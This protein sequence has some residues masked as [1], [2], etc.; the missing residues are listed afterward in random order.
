M[1]AG[2]YAP[3]GEGVCVSW[4][5]NDQSH[6]TRGYSVRTGALALDARRNLHQYRVLGSGIC[7]IHVM[8]TAS[9][10]QACYDWWHDKP[11]F[12][13]PTIILQY[14]WIQPLLLLDLDLIVTCIMYSSVWGQIRVLQV[15]F[16]FLEDGCSTRWSCNL[17]V[18]VKASWPVDQGNGTG[19]QWSVGHSL[20]PKDLFWEILM[21]RSWMWHRFSPESSIW[22]VWKG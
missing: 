9:D 11:S 20:T 6:M 10:S 2:L 19:Q 15:H 17:Y 16:I 8:I 1:A 7:S 3:L 5:M 4:L 13:I 21:W 12:M 14:R 22:G 18:A